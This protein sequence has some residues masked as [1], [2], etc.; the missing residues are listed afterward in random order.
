M[1][2]TAG[3]VS[4]LEIVKKQ[5]VAAE[6]PVGRQLI[7]RN[8]GNKTKE[9]YNIDHGCFYSSR[10][11]ETLT[12]IQQRRI[13]KRRNVSQKKHRSSSI[14][15]LFSGISDSPAPLARFRIALHLHQ[16]QWFYSSLDLHLD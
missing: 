6:N 4:V 7:G 2:K 16:I 11:K 8:S 10:V 5:L 13:N 9:L 1:T 12:C 3:D 15:W 14:V